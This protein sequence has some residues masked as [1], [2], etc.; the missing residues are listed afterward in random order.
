[1]ATRLAMAAMAVPSVGLAAM[2]IPS[3]AMAAVAMAPL[4]VGLGLMPCDLRSDA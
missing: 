3:V 4:A 2:E 1:M